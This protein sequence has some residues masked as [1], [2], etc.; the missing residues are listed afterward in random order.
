M[1]RKTKPPSKPTTFRLTEG[2]RAQLEQAA[3][4]L[5][6]TPSALARRLV[7]QALDGDEGRGLE[8]LKLESHLDELTKRTN[9][10]QQD[11]QELKRNL[12][13]AVLALLVRADPLS[14]A[15]ANRWAKE[16]LTK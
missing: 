6:L 2:E 16:H 13:N 3:K 14:A 8:F 4:R 15:E 5:N 1:R 7:V 11:T 9:E 10:N 12:W